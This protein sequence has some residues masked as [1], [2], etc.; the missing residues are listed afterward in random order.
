MLAKNTLALR[1]TIDTPVARV[2]PNGAR[3]TPGRAAGRHART[4]HVRAP[5]AGVVGGSALRATLTR[6]ATMHSIIW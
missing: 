3:I 5:L 2:A 4:A 6:S 1:R